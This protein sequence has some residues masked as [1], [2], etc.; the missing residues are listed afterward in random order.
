MKTARILLAVISLAALA[1][2]GNDSI[3]GSPAPGGVRHD[4]APATV[5]NDST[6][7]SGAGSITEETPPPPCSG[8]LVV[9]TDPSGNVTTTCV[10]GDGKG[11]LLG[12]GG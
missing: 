5:S 10:T 8:T 1:A 9:T 12:S 4:T 11:G 3:T 2:C 6:E 7:D